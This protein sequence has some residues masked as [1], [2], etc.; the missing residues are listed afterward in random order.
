MYIFVKIFEG[1][2][3]LVEIKELVQNIIYLLNG[4]H[5]DNSS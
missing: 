1:K 2:G 5:L 4:W 3:M